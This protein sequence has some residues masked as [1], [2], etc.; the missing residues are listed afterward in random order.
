MGEAKTIAD[1]GMDEVRDLL[2]FEKE[3]VMRKSG[4][5]IHAHVDLTE[6]SEE[7]GAW[8]KEVENFEPTDFFNTGCPHCQPF[9]D[10]GAIMVST[11]EDLVGI[12]PVGN[13][14]VE[15][16]WLRSNASLG[17]LAEASNQSA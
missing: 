8:E 10:D 16:V 13:G 2:Q 15:T 6:E 9:L 17:N 7:L 11:S 14:Q 4:K 5:Y 12:R 1:M 3:V